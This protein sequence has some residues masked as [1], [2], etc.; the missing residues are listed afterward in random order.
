METESDKVDIKNEVEDC[1]KAE[2][3]IQNQESTLLFFNFISSPCLIP[4]LI[5]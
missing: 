4:N 1:K 5:V 2:D 3:Q